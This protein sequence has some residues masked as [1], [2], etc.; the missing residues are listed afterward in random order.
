MIVSLS[1]AETALFILNGCFSE[2]VLESPFE[3][4]VPSSIS[5]INREKA[6]SFYLERGPKVGN[7]GENHSI[8]MDPPQELLPPLNGMGFHECSLEALRP[9]CSGVNESLVEIVRSLFNENQELRKK[10]KKLKKKVKNLKEKGNSSGKSTK[11]KTLGQIEA[12]MSKAEEKERGKV[13][14]N[15]KKGAEM[16]SMVHM[17]SSSY[18]KNASVLTMKRKNKSFIALCEAIETKREKAGNKTSQFLSIVENN[19]E[20]L[21]EFSKDIEALLA[22]CPK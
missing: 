13:E 9:S 7:R 22:L 19:P 12:R 21:D 5:P 1:V 18:Q 14:G 16:G 8:P 3:R 11:E 6:G 4:C 15:Q 17:E 20:S 2:P 10:N